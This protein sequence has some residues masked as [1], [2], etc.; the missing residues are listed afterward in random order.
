MKTKSEITSTPIWVFAGSD[1]I[2]SETVTQPYILC[3]R[4]ILCRRDSLWDGNSE[5]DVTATPP[6]H[7]H[8]QP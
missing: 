5:T 8:T 6:P 4:K 2:R 7:T 1:E 3:L